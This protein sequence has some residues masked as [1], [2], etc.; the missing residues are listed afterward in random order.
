EGGSGCMISL[1]GFPFRPAVRAVR[2]PGRSIGP[3]AANVPRMTTAA[4]DPA[5]DG[6]AAHP[7]FAQALRDLGL[8]HLIAEVRRFPDATRTAAEAAAAVGCELRQNCKSLILSSDVVPDQVLML[9]APR[10]RL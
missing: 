8:E 3:P 6:S 9:G 4:H 7:R 5:P 2:H 10:R 1:K